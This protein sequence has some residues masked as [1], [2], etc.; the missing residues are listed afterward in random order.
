MQFITWL[1]LAMSA[2]SPHGQTV[3]TGVV[4]HP[5]DMDKHEARWGITLD[6]RWLCGSDGDL[7]V[8]DSLVATARF[9][10]LLKVD[11]FTVGERC[12]E[13]KWKREQDPSHCYRIERSRLA[14]RKNKPRNM[15]VAYSPPLGAYG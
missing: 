3:D 12:D 15:K 1:E 2:V 9:L 14:L 11:R 5:L 13:N 7:T 10:H 6:K 4:V 8:F